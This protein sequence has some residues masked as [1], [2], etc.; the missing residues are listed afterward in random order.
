MSLRT[1]FIFLITMF[2]VPFAVPHVTHAAVTCTDYYTRSITVP[3][4]YGAGYNPFTSA[5]ELLIKNSNCNDTSITMSVGNGDAAMYIYK[6]GYYWTGSGWQKVNL[7]SSSV[8]QT[9]NWYTGEAHADVPMTPGNSERYYVGHTC[10]KVSDIWKCGCRD[11][12]CSLAYW[13]L[14]KTI[15]TSAAT[16]NNNN[17]CDAG[18]TLTSCP[19]DCDG[20]A[21]SCRKAWQ[22][23]CAP[24]SYWN[25]PFGSGAQYSSKSDPRVVSLNKHNRLYMNTVSWGVSV[26]K[27]ETDDPDV[28]FLP[29]K[30]YSTYTWN[31]QTITLKGKAG[32]QVPIAGNNP[33]DLDDGFINVVQPDDKTDFE[34]SFYGRPAST[35][36]TYKTGPVYTWDARGSC[37]ADHGFNG[38]YMAGPTIAGL[39]RRWEVEGTNQIRH[40]LIIGLCTDQLKKGYI[41]PA[42]FEDN[43]SDKYSGEVPVGTMFA[44]PPSVDIESLGLNQYGKKVAYAIQRYGAIVSLQG[45]GPMLVGE[46]ALDNGGISASIRSNLLKIMRQM[47]VVTNTTKATPKGG[48]TSG[49]PQAP[50]FCA[51]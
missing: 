47:V 8:L 51:L 10:Q 5:K 26:Y 21:G 22:W 24:D 35:A 16:C 40:A 42:T 48:G 33:N 18:E 49:I 19:N 28:T 6:N 25:L 50:A 23:P 29:S 14:Q 7:T 37:H 12:N 46:P 11:T 30:T 2:V 9:D 3:T 27:A 15:K 20:S 31:G 41:W 45:C 34:T 44:I 39:V 43:F 4:G 36:T 13:Q 17:V 38:G 32:M 1:L